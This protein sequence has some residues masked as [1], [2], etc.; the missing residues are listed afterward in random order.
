MFQYGVYL[1]SLELQGYPTKDVTLKTTV[2]L[3][4]SR[5][6]TSDVHCNNSVTCNCF[7][8]LFNLMQG[9]VSLK[10]QTKKTSNSLDLRSYRWSLKWHPLWVTLYYNFRN[11]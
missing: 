9:R 4:A 2:H 10:G 8:K 11:P 7:A 1:G 3:F 6:I 5:I